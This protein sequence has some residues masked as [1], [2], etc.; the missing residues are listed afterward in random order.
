MSVG[1]DIRPAMPSDFNAVESWLASAGLPTADITPEHLSDFLVATLDGALI[2][3]IGLE[4]TDSVGLLRSLVVDPSVRGGGIGFQ[5][6]EKLESMAKKR[7]ISELWLLTID[8]DG[9]FMKL[10]YGRRERV[11]API[12]IQSTAEFSD[13]C[14]GDA[15]LMSKLL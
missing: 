11:E 8:A 7:G 3:V 4:Q 2:G 5:L 1:V 14:P 9:Y 13:L 10:R 15:V 6:V 12:D